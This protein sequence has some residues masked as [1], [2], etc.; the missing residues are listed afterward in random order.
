MNAE[1]T[2]KAKAIIFYLEQ[3]VVLSN[4][5]AAAPPEPDDSAWRIDGGLGWQSEIDWPVYAINAN[6]GSLIMKELSLYSGNISSAPYG[7]ELLSAF[8]PK[9]NVR[10]YCNIN[11][12]D[13]SELP[14]LWAFLLI[15]M[16]MLIAMIAVTSSSMHF[17]QRRRRRRLGQLLSS[18]Q[19]DLRTLGIQLLTVPQDTIDSFP[20]FVYE[21]HRSTEDTGGSHRSSTDKPTNDPSSMQEADDLAG[22]GHSIDADP[23]ADL[24]IDLPPIST[25][26]RRSPPFPQ[27]TCPICLDDYLA[28]GT[29]VRFLPCHHIFHPACIDPMLSEYSTLCPVCKA[30]VLPERYCPKKIT[31]TM[32][33]Q[34]RA[35]RGRRNT[36]SGRT[37]PSVPASSGGFPYVRHIFGRHRGPPDAG[38]S[39]P[40]ESNNLELGGVRSSPQHEGSGTGTVG[41]LP[42]ARP[43]SVPR[44]VWARQR[45]TAIFGRQARAG[46]TQD[47][48]SR[49]RP[50]CT[51]MNPQC[52]A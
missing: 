22:K 20:L 40:E 44:T 6:E 3:G 50:R 45:A 31:N 28:D 5:T 23:K 43:P 52:N 47:P 25:L 49:A 29:I 48:A 21:A 12:S 11:T 7:H 10:L 17:I 26:P 35:S 32:V 8:S 4:Q 27:P 14:S 19:V 2:E 24:G 30:S 51:S 15:V 37:R 41:S 16:G 18:G 34:Q 36:A 39:Q 33:R 46:A 1:D 38:R 9:D 42:A 13:T